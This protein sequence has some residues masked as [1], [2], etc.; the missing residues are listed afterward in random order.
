MNNPWSAVWLGVALAI[1]ITTVM[2]ATGY[3]MFSALPLAPLF[4]LFWWWQKFSRAQVGFA[5]GKVRH[6]GLALAY[7][8][9]VV[10][11]LALIALAIGAVD[12]SGT[13]WNKTLINLAVMTLSTALV[14]IVTEEGFFRGWLWASFKH[15]DRSDRQ[16]LVLT[17]LIFAAW[18]ISAVS[19]ETGFDLPARQIP[20]YL[21]NATLIG[22]NWGLLRLASGSIIVASIS[23][24]LWNG[25]AYLL[26]GFGDETGAL[27]IEETWLYGP[28]TGL[29]GIALNL[30]FVAWL[31]R[32]CRV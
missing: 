27:G 18:H 30:A 5:W 15:A 17:S 12:V 20:I 24:G 9:M 10:P 31:W 3:S 23:H 26:F 2:D 13:D 29:L 21:V 8:L 11:A 28:E 19:L 22:M 7:P 1:A 16:V 4:F 14:T 6:Y 25:L 32:K